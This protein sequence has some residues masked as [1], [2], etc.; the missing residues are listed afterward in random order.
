MVSDLFNDTNLQFQNGARPQLCIDEQ[1]H[2]T[3]E[4]RQLS[5]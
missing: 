4:P 3:P 1:K 2:P 5:F